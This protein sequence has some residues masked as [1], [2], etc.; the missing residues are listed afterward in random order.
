MLELH[1]S[2]FVY[3]TREHM[4]QTLLAVVDPETYKKFEEPSCH[5]CTIL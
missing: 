1:G 4:L 3:G 5:C 2:N